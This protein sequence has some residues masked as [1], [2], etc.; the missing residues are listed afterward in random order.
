MAVLSQIKGGPDNDR[1]AMQGLML[2]MY[3]GLFFNLVVWALAA[4]DRLLI[5]YAAAIAAALAAQGVVLALTLKKT[6]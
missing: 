3:S 6:A 2:G 5:A 1:R 4:E